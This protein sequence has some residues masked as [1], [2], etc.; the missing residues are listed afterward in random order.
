MNREK[1]MSLARETLEIISAGRYHR[2]PSG[3]S[4][5]ISNDLKAA[6]AGS[7]VYRPHD[8]PSDFKTKASADQQCETLVEV[9]SETTLQAAHRLCLGDTTSDLLCLNFASA[10]NPGGG[11]LSGS[12]A[13]EESLARSSGLYPCISQMTE[14]YDHN[15]RLGTCLYSDHM[16]Y[17]PGVPVFRDDSG[18]LLDQPY[19]LAFITAPAV[20]AGAV[21]KN[22]PARVNQIRPVMESRLAKV[23]WIA[24]QNGHQR[25]ILGAWGCGVFGNDPSTVAAIFAEALGPAGRFYGCFKQVVYAI[26]DRSSDQAIAKAFAHLLHGSRSAP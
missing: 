21:K 15:R 14:M 11:F 26:Y 13:Q 6:I 1:R 19:K 23:L 20:N 18:E 12:Q 22:E 4:I 2:A 9:T 3:R 24:Q 7:R 25:L 5:D 17:S 16:I 10:K 8:F